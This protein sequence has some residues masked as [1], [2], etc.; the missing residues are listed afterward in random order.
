MREEEVAWIWSLGRLLVLEAIWSTVPPTLLLLLLVFPST[1]KE[2]PICTW[3]A[4]VS[5]VLSIKR[6]HPQAR[7]CER[8]N[9]AGQGRGEER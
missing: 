7:W 4:N 2:A 6:C 9:R 1:G 8:G 5:L 3:G